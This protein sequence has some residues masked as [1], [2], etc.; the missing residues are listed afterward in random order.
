[1]HSYLLL[2]THR[3]FFNVNRK[4]HVFYMLNIMKNLQH[5]YKVLNCNTA[6]CLATFLGPRYESPV[7]KLLLVTKEKTKNYLLFATNNV[8]GVQNMTP[9]DGNPYKHT[10]M[11]CHPK[12]VY[13]FFYINNIIITFQI[14]NFKIE[15]P[16]VYIYSQKNKD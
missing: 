16:F 13:S 5:K 2:L 15:L 12:Q 4:R 1:M 7:N 8:I 10:G 14:I 3:I 9:L 6:E 11:I